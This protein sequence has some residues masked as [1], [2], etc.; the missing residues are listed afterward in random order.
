MATV[1][2]AYA[3]CNR[4]VQYDMPFLA[5]VKSFV[6]LCAPTGGEVV[7]LTDPCFEDGT[8]VQLQG[9]AESNPRLRVV[10]HT[11]DLSNP[12]ADGIE[13][14]TARKM[15]I[16]SPASP[17]VLVPFDVDEVIHEKDLGRLREL[18][19]EM[20]GR[21]WRVVSCGTVPWRN[22]PH[23]K[24]SD[25]IYKPRLTLNDG[26][27]THGI[28]KSCRFIGPTGKV[29]GN[30]HT[31]GAGLL[32]EDTEEGIE[33]NFSACEPHNVRH[34]SQAELDKDRARYVASLLNHTHVHIHH[35]SWFDIPRK[36]AMDQT[37]WYL[38]HHLRGEYLNG[39]KDYT[40]FKEDDEPVDFDAI[41]DARRATTAYESAIIDEMSS[42]EV[43]RLDWLPHPEYV[44]SWVDSPDR[45]LWLGLHGQG[46]SVGLMKPEP[47]SKNPYLR[48]KKRRADRR[49][50]V[51]D[52]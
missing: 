36:W 32:D 14:A 5:S 45:R 38:W 50:P 15:A 44:Q 30:E 10:E 19:D 43:V 51:Y 20:V 13:K 22:G 7:V 25:V 52:F 47:E 1:I 4:G 9:L 35:Y 16:N 27:T 23:V 2:S 29:H 41:I 21:S 6:D 39:L 37:W 11:W 8:L 40:T 49:D 3:Y 48:W 42:P 12:G 34:T 31:D 28:P 17:Q 24:L 33:G 26:R 18:A 46:K